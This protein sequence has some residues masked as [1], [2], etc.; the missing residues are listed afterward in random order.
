MLTY[1][2]L[3]EI[4]WGDDYPGSTESLRVH[5]NRLREKIEKDPANPGLSEPGQARATT[6]RNLWR[7]RRYIH[8]SQPKEYSTAGIS[9]YIT[10]AVA[11]GLYYQG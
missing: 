11:T 5:I 2:G 1:S 10:D 4:M 9:G 3:A 8:S 6:L 7:T